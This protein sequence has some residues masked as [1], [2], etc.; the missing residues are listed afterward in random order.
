VVLD[1][2]ERASSRRAYPKEA[3]MALVTMCTA[4]AQ[5]YRPDGP[6]RPDQIADRYADPAWPCSA[7]GPARPGGVDSRPPLPT[8]V[9]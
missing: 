7:T 2:V 9:H 3:T 6:L 1:G 4:V 5:W 8:R